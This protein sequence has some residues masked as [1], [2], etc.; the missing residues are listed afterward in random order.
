MEGGY[1]IKTLF[2]IY[3]LLPLIILIE[4]FVSVATEI[5]A[6]RQLLPV[7]GGSVIVT[8]LIIGFFLLFLALGYRKGGRM[9]ENLSNSLS[10]NFFFSAIWLGIGL[11]YIFILL[12]FNA[13]QKITGENLFYPFIIYL[14]VIISPLIYVLGQT[15]PVTMNMV[16]QNTSAGMIGGN[17]L[18]LSTAGS[19]LG[20]IITA[21]LFMNFLGVAWT[22]FINFTLLLTLAL[23]LA[24]NKKS[25]VKQ[26]AVAILMIF[27]VY[28]F[29]IRVENKLFILTNNYANYQILDSKNSNL[30]KGEK[31]LSI[32]NSYSSYINEANKGF[33]Y[34]ETIK[35]ILFNDMKLNNANILVLG[36]GGFTLSAENTYGNHFTYVDIDKEI[37]NV[38]IPQ[39]LAELK[40]DLIIDD[41]RHYIHSTKNQFQVIIVDTFTNNRT[42]PSY[43]LTD[44]YISELQKKLTQKGTIIFN[45]IAKPS[46]DDPYSKHVDNTIRHT[47]KNCMVTP[48]NYDNMA[49]N[50][51]YVCSNSTNQM[52]KKIYSDNLSTSSTDAFVWH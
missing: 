22:I 19:F 51:L 52:D 46:L 3:R 12:F 41:A 5:L 17:T 4:G 44:E 20:A 23:L 36:A 11:S 7:V 30:S 39:F 48:L 45:I 15:V 40:D 34:I 26:L 47:F 27:M 2:P 43:L 6:I 42:I 16:K 32:N 33:K 21:L 50:I 28:L 38:T 18:G 25:L 9:G 10:Y 24:E 31:I 13:V 8:S 29:N 49:T 35:K 1:E 14:L 37:K